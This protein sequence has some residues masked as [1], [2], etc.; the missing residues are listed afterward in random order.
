MIELFSKSSSELNIIKK[1]F[2]N[3]NNFLLSKVKEIN[4]KYAQLKKRKFCKNCKGKKLKYFF[5]SF[6]VDYFLCKKCNHLNGGF[7]ESKKFL[8]YLYSSNSGKNYSKNY[9]KNYKKR[10][11]EI[12]IPKAK[13]LKKI[14]GKINII[15]IGSGDGAFLKACEKQKISAV[16]LEPNN[17]MLKFAEKKLK[18]NKIYF[19]KLDK[20]EIPHSKNNKT[21][22]VAIGVIEHLFDPSNFFHLFNKS[23]CKY[24]FFSVPLFSL[25]VILENSFKNIYPRHLGGAHTHLYTEKSINYILK[26]FKLKKKAA[27]WFGQDIVDLNRA[28]KITSN[29]NY[30]DNYLKN[31]VSKY[32][33]KDIDK[34]QNFF[35]KK[36][37]CSEVHMIVEKT[38]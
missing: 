4:S 3:K 25:S 10:V 5:N 36:K 17:T 34:I 38:N 26:K 30:K 7:E 31:F 13:F 32:F 27:W 19:S 2:L 9:I 21:C 14:L 8:N 33:D 23:K 22:I 15:E 37:I 12:Y 29:I 18:K 11:N 6:K 16:G 1:N 28:L 20:L 24:L 35:D